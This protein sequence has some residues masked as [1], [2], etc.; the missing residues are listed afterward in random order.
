[1][2]L[3]HIISFI[4]HSCALHNSFKNFLITTMA[5]AHK[6]RASSN[7]FLAL[8]LV[9]K[10]DAPGLIELEP[11]TPHTHTHTPPHVQTHTHTHTHIYKHTHA[12]RSCLPVWRRVRYRVGS[13][14]PAQYDRRDPHAAWLRR[15]YVESEEL[16]LRTC[17]YFH[18][19]VALFEGL[20]FLAWIWHL[21]A[22]VYPW[23]RTGERENGGGRWM[24]RG[25]GEGWSNTTKHINVYAHII[26]MYIHIWRMHIYMYMYCIHIHA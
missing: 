20:W 19:R 25:W 26:Q 14:C 7:T 18:V 4:T 21:Y 12:S 8:D 2:V 3:K 23:G 10:K 22:Q 16:F 1:M 15:A 24:R 13:T 11:H 5:W 6:I 17:D 9:T